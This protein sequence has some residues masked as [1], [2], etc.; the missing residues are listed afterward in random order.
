MDPPF[1]QLAFNQLPNNIIRVQTPTTEC[2][3][4]VQIEGDWIVL[5]DA[6]RTGTGQVEYA[7]LANPAAEPRSGRSSSAPRCST[8]TRLAATAPGRETPAAMVVAAMVAAIGGGA[9]G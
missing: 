1:A 6:T 5:A 3:W 7:V 8:C 4:D 9:G 2:T